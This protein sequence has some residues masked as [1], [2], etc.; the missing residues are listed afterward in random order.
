M[1]IQRLLQTTRLCICLAIQPPTLAFFRKAAWSRPSPSHPLAMP[2]H[3]LRRPLRRAAPSRRRTVDPA[4]LPRPLPPACRAAPACRRISCCSW[5]RIRSCRHLGWEAEERG[6]KADLVGP[7]H[8]GK[9]TEEEDDRDWGSSGGFNSGRAQMD[10]WWS[11]DAVYVRNWVENKQLRRISVAKRA[12]LGGDELTWNRLC[13]I[14]WITLYN[15]GV[16]YF[17]KGYNLQI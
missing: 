3:P 7:V 5:P 4:R 8:G 16:F 9:K 11:Y 2:C 13:L 6:T 14:C 15:L 1:Q 12:Q 10:W 17:Y